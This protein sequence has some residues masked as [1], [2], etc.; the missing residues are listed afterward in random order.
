[1]RVKICGITSF[2]DAINSI[3]AG[4]YALGFVFYKDSPRYISPKKAYNIIKKL[5]P[6]IKIVGLF[7]NDSIEDINRISKISNID[8]AQIITTNNTSI[9]YNSLDIPYIKVLRV[10]NKDDI[11]KNYNN[12]EYILID[13]YVSTFGGA[14]RRVDLSFFH[15]IDCSKIILAGGLN[16]NNIEELKD[17]NFY[18][19]DVS[20]GVEISKGIKDKN[21]LISFIN[22][23]NEI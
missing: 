18:A 4:A 16:E 10:K 6:F 13:S 17:Y 19:I 7:V 11:I 8:I 9:Y 2:Y 1:M 22:K 5:P 20:S 15:D 21:K 14:G 3:N 23:A 12:D